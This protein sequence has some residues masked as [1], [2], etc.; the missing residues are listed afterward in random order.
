MMPNSDMRDKFV[1]YIHKLMLDSFTGILLGARAR[2][3]SV[4]P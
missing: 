1:Y 3:N 2:I 4:L